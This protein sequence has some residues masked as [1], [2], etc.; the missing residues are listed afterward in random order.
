M[1][2][3]YY[4]RTFITT[5]PPKNNLAKVESDGIDYEGI[6]ISGKRILRDAA[7]AAAF[8]TAALITYGAF[9]TYKGRTELDWAYPGKLPQNCA[10]LPQ[11]YP[12]R[13]RLSQFL[14]DIDLGLFGK[15]ID[16][17]FTGVF[18]YDT[19]S[20]ALAKQ[21]NIKLCENINKAAAHVLSFKEN[22]MHMAGHVAK[23]YFAPIMLGT[24]AVAAYESVSV[25]NEREEQL[26]EKRFENQN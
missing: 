21:A 12:C 26:G 6:K 3:V 13:G 9:A 24:A 5:N 25:A 2:T 17:F 19:G 14:Y 11:P 20:E 16:K 10:E 23:N 15:G 7:L 18:S 8:A 22:V 1:L 4:S